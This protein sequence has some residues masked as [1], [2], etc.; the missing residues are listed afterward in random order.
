MQRILGDHSVPR[1]QHAMLSCGPA[2][3]SSPRLSGSL[4]TRLTIMA[5]NAIMATM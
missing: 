3:R 5:M 1:L 2:T 4:G